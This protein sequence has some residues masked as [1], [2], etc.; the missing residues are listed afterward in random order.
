MTARPLLLF[1]IAVALFVWFETK[2][3][4]PPASWSDS[5]T[6]E[7]AELSANTGARSAGNAPTI[8]SKSDATAQWNAGSITLTREP[9]GH[10]YAQPLA[11]NTPIRM[12]VDTGATVVALTGQDAR[13]MGISW[14]SNDMRPV[15]RGANGMVNGVEVTIK[16]MDLGNVTVTNVPAIVLPE[17]LAVSLLGQSFLNRLSRMEVSGDRMVLGG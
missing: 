14:K 9:D 13:S 3:A 7:L 16:R 12:M 5:G 10:F 4:A 17:G 11:N 8:P 15:A 1:I 6:G 2:D